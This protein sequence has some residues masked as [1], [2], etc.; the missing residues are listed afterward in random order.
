MSYRS[1]LLPVLLLPAALGAQIFGRATPAEQSADSAQPTVVDSASPR[2][3]VQRF[4]EA[5]G[6]GD[7][8]T[9]ASALDLAAPSAASRGEELARRLK[10]VL[11]SKLWIDLERV[12][13]R[14][15]GDTTDGLPRDREVLG[16]VELAKDKVVAI[17][18]A[19]LGR[20]GDRRWVFSPATIAQVDAMYEAMPDNWI[21]EHLPVQL[22]NPGPFEILRWQ[23]IA[24]LILIPLSM[25]IG[26]LMERP[27][28]AVLRK[29]TARTETQF[30]DMLIASARGPIILLWGVAVSR[31]LLRWIALV[32]PVQSFIVSL[33][34][35]IATAAIFWLVIRAIG[36]LQD[37]LP[38]SDWG[39]RHPALRSLVPLGGRIMTLMIFLLA[40]LT[41]VSQFGYSVATIVAGLGIGGIAIALGA[42]KSLE[43]FFGSVS[44]G[45]D[46][47][48]R[49][50]DW[51]MVN[52]IEGE[53][54]AI[55]LRSTRIRTMERTLISI[56]NGKLAET[57]TEN[58]APRD[59]IRLKTMI[60]LEYGT[61][62]ATI[63]T[64]RDEIEKALKA[65]PRVWQ[66]RIVVRVHSFG[67]FA[68][69]IQ[70][71][72]WIDTI[73]IDEFREV[74]ETLL[75]EIMEIVERH[76]G[77]FAFPTHNVHLKQPIQPL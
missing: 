1:L 40:V 2:F 68:I 29:L 66:D 26:W 3:A 33:Q 4:L 42:Q 20:G 18:L 59:R 5:A 45:V 57:Q 7:F 77:S 24:L 15:E 39:T 43:H 50:G 8:A 65:N 76:G 49:V 38:A 30:D 28:R 17:R 54:E 74:R 75:L 67:D 69:N 70:A 34:G 61:P 6:S 71:F 46:Q 64:V 11:D 58:F 23:W 51:I 9:A 27:T 21:R 48:F 12:S 25:I 55:G 10:A 36:V 62:A 47:P 32:T 31:I 19:R 37:T 72:C 73:V 63:R 53:V 60:G 56:P 35:A 16:T 41:V 14:A 44:I 22:L 52:G 13:P